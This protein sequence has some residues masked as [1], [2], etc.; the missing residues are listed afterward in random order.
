VL[1]ALL[2][3]NELTTPLPKSWRAFLWS[4]FAFLLRITMGLHKCQQ[5]Q[6]QQS[7]FSSR[8]MHSVTGRCTA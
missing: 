1:V 6:Q 2:A 5:Q 4:E 8:F 7:L 3:C